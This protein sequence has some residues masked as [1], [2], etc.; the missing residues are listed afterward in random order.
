MN[1]EHTNKPAHVTEEDV[2]KPSNLHDLRRDI[3]GALDEWANG[4]GPVQEV[5]LAIDKLI[6]WWINESRN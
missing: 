2:V 5:A 4:G 6:Q 1:G 3:C